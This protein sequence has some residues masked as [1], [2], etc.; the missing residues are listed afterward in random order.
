MADLYIWELKGGK[1][2]GRCSKGLSYAKDLQDT[3]GL[4][5]LVKLRLFFYKAL[6]LRQL[7][8]SWR[9]VILSTINPCQW[10]AGSKE[11]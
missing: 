8:T 1:D 10:A 5:I 6:T 2:K 4:A 7:G 9:K 11:T 3:G